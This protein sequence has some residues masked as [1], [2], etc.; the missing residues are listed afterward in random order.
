MKRIKISENRLTKIVRESINNI[1]FEG[2]ENIDG[3]Y[4]VYYNGEPMIVRID[5]TVPIVIFGDYEINGNEAIDAINSI[6]QFMDYNNNGIE[7]AIEQYM[8]DSER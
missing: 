6:T 8:Y 3:D 2:N 7:D 1:L 4:E 5:S